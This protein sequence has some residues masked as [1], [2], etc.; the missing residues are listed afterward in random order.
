MFLSGEQEHTEVLRSATTVHL[1]A[2]T[3]QTLPLT[4]DS[5]PPNSY[6]L[7]HFLSNQPALKVIPPVLQVHHHASESSVHNPLGPA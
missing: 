1:G 6:S 2:L 7:Y 4:T 5:P 3:G